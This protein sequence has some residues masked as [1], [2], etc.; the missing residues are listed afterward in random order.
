MYPCSRVSFPCSRVSF[1]CSC[2]STVKFRVSSRVCDTLLYYMMLK[3]ENILQSGRGGKLDFDNHLSFLI[4]FLEN[5]F[6]KNCPKRI[7]NSNFVKLGSEIP[8]HFWQKNG[9]LLYGKCFVCCNNLS[10]FDLL[11]K[12]WSCHQSGKDAVKENLFDVR[13]RKWSNLRYSDSADLQRC[14]WANF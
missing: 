6:Q 10:D 4:I 1:A 13:L 9:R 2:V 12:N 7:F 8:I 3:K 5:H 14:N 11:Q